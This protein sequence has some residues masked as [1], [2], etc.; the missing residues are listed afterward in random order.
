MSLF[1]APVKRTRHGF[2]VRLGD[3][4]TQLVLRLLGELR[5]LLAADVP[6]AD[7]PSGDVP[8]GDVPGERS[9]EAPGVEALTARLFPVANP[10]DDEME[11]EYQRLMR[12]E[13]ITSRVSAIATVEDLLTSG[14]QIDEA[15]MTAFMQS[16]NAVRLVLGT[17]LDI[18]DDAPDAHRDTGGSSA[19]TDAEAAAELEDTPEYHLYAY[20]SWLLEHIVRALSGR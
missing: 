17:M 3:D 19:G 5:A 18:S 2:T 8:A 16:V 6:P 14:E 1:R 20:L 4:E 10:D 15:Q 12:D 11:A 9:A 7:V 13:L